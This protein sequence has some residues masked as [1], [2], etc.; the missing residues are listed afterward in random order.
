MFRHWR[1]RFRNEG[2]VG[3]VQQAVSEVGLG[4]EE[5]GTRLGGWHR[6]QQLS[7]CLGLMSVRWAGQC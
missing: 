4:R 5:F 2:R 7:V 3:G 1:G 6:R